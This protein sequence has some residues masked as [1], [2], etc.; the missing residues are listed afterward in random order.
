M[1]FKD[2]KFWLGSLMIGTAGIGIGAFSVFL[3]TF[4]K[5]FGYGKVHTQLLTLIPYGFSLVALLFFAWL[6]DHLQQKALISLG[7][8]LVSCAGFVILLATTN[9]VVG[10]A[11]SCFVAAGAYPALV[12]GVAFLLPLHGG[13]TKRATSNWGSQV[14][15]QCYSIISTQV[16]RTPPRFFLGHGIALG[17]YAIGVLSNLA[18]YIIVKRANA[19]RDQVQREWEARGEV[20]PDMEKS[21]EDLGDFHPAYRYAI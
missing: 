18:L 16:Y 20:N 4:I 15:V 17:L 10:I 21:F 7:C 8:S 6:A 13:Y 9:P 1:C 3:P 19:A 12:V 5:E 14:F 2:I 11:G